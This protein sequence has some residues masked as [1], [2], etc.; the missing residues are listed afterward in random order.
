MEKFRIYG[1][2]CLKGSVDISG[3]ADF[4]RRDFGGRAGDI[5]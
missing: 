1:K 2:T 4:V 5:D 3:A